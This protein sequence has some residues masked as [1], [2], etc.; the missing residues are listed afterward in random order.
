MGQI[1]G[2]RDGLQSIILLNR[3][4]RFAC[5]LPR[6]RSY[7]PQRAKGRKDSQTFSNQNQGLDALPVK[8]WKPSGTSINVLRESSITSGRFSKGL[9]GDGR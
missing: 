5:A 1:S 9:M 3:T 7:R 8:V 2:A 4:R 6:R